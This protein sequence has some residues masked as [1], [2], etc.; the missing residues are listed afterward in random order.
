MRDNMSI[1]NVESPF[2]VLVALHSAFD[3][4]GKNAILW[5]LT[6]S[7]SIFWPSYLSPQDPCVHE[8]PTAPG[9][10]K[11]HKPTL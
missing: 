10:F 7:V 4:R 5:C 2:V 11:H 3:G 1:M 6:P 8:V 9:Q